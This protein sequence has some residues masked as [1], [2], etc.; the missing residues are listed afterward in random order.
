MI[1]PILITIS[2]ALMLASCAT[3][4]KN[5][6]SKPNEPKA[7]LLR[8]AEVKTIWIP[9][10]IEGNRYEEGHFIHLIDK[11]ASWSGQ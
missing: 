6:P 1:K 9:D 4:S 11:P 8:S 7:P 3:T 10:R 5:A 2:S